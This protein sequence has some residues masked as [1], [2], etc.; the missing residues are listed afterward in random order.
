MAILNLRAIIRA[1]N[2]CKICSSLPKNRKPD[3]K[4]RK[5]GQQAKKSRPASPLLANGKEPAACSSKISAPPYSLRQPSSHVKN[6]G[7]S[8]DSRESSQSSKKKASEKYYSSLQ[9]QQ[10]RLH[11]ESS[12]KRSKNR[13]SVTRTHHWSTKTSSQSQSSSPRSSHDVITPNTVASKEVP[14]GRGKERACRSKRRARKGGD[15]LRMEATSVS[16]S[17]QTEDL[18]APPPYKNNKRFR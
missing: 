1:H 6:S 16:V 5:C 13:A 4:S 10:Q 9:K 2:N 12:S 8:G 14:S 17:Q 11:V 15:T 3:S 7:K 18:N